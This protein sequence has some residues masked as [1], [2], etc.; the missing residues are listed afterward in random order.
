MSGFEV[1][2]LANGIFPRS[3]VKKLAFNYVIKLKLTA[4]IY[5]RCC[6]IACL[7]ILILSLLFKTSIQQNKCNFEQKYCSGNRDVIARD[8]S[9]MGGVRSH[10]PAPDVDAEI[11][12]PYARNTFQGNL[13][14]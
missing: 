9:Y 5:L 14:K 13:L 8:S 12:V 11:L 1:I 10:F 7:T 2:A 4:V 3:M 6:K